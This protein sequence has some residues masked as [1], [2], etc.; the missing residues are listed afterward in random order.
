MVIIFNCQR[1]DTVLHYPQSLMQDPSLRDKD[2]VTVETEIAALVDLSVISAIVIIICTFPLKPFWL[3]LFSS[4]K[5]K[6]L[7]LFKDC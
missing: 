5:P 6:T 2:A 7:L 4:Q 1:V 3:P